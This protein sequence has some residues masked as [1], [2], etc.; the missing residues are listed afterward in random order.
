MQTAPL[1]GARNQA[2][3]GWLAAGVASSVLASLT[4]IYLA[5]VTID[6]ATGTY[7]EGEVGVYWVAIGVAAAMTVTLWALAVMC[8]RASRPSD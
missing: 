2:H 7:I 8:F 4:T 5:W 1:G 3:P 6:F